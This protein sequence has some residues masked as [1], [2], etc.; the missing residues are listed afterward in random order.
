MLSEELEAYLDHISQDH[1]AATVASH[2]STLTRLV[3]EVQNDDITSNELNLQWVVEYLM[4]ASKNYSNCTL[5]GKISTI[6]NFFAYLRNESPELI[7]KRI[8]AKL[9]R[10]GITGNKGNVPSRSLETTVG[11]YLEYVR[12]RAYGTR[13]HAATE[14]I[15]ATGCRLKS[16]RALNVGDVDLDAGTIELSIPKKHAVS[17]TGLVTYRT[18]TLPE[19]TVRALRTYI[20]HER[21]PSSSTDGSEPLF[22]T[23]QG[24]ASAATLRRSMQAMIDAA[25]SSSRNNDPNCGVVEDNADGKGL[26]LSPHSIRQYYIN[27][28]I[29]E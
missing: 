5:Q 18:E 26:Q 22:T 7:S 15:A 23:S 4:K 12:N 19:G 16:L 27:Q 10:E 20:E 2:K 25:C 21:V 24:R 1:C 9:T 13:V 8:E 11:T 28:L 3:I 14:I 6:A 17:R 29:E